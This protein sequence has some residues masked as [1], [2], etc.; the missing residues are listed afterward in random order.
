VLGLL[1][2]LGVLTLA[3]CGDSGTDSPGVASANGDRGSAPPSASASPSADSQG[4]GFA[5]CMRENGVPDFPDPNPDGSF[6][7]SRLDSAAVQRALPAC[8]SLLP[9]GESGQLDPALADKLR[10]FAQCMR[11]NGVQIPDPDPN[12]SDPSLGSLPVNPNDPAIRRTVDACQKKVNLPVG[13]A[14]GRSG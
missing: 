8:R 3:G 11:D 5:A 13:P 7:R 2:I 6:D 10:Q 9:G 14:P 1:G 4:R 12:S